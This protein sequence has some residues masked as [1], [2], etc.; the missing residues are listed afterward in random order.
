MTLM[1]PPDM[2][3]SNRFREGGIVAWVFTNRQLEGRGGYWVLSPSGNCWRYCNSVLP[4]SCPLEQCLQRV[5]PPSSSLK[6][7][8][9][10]W[11]NR[12]EPASLQAPPATATPHTFFLIGGRNL[13]RHHGG[14]LRGKNRRIFAS[15][16]ARGWA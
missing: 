11:R 14:L 2:W 10:A 3:T 5:L 15:T 4:R 16:F 13:A 6:A 9:G 7:P 1:A 12:N 8:R